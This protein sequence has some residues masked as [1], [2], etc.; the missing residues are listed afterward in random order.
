MNQFVTQ[1]NY[2]IPNN[3]G[4][5]PPTNAPPRFNG[6]LGRYISDF[7][8]LTPGETPMDGSLTVFPTKGLDAIYIRTWNKDG[9]LL[10]F[11]YILDESVDLN[12]PQ[13]APQPPQPDYQALLDRI[14]SLEEQVKKSQQRGGRNNSAN[15]NEEVSS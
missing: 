3:A 1:P 10:S 15:K 5:Q 11:R 9:R 12:A 4:A 2:L 13:M 7:S 6:F 8:E 14:S